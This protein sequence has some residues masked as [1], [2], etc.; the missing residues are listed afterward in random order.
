MLIGLEGAHVFWMSIFGGSER[1]RDI[2][3]IVSALF[4]LA[5]IRPTRAGEAEGYNQVM[6]HERRTSTF[7]LRVSQEIPWRRVNRRT[8]A[9]ETFE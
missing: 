8:I 1:L 4:R 9:S 5:A 6:R 7:I 3:V 2:S